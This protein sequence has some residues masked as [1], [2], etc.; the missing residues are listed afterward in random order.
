MK[1]HFSGI[2]GVYYHQDSCDLNREIYTELKAGYAIEIFAQ[3][4]F[5][6]RWGKSRI[7]QNENIDTL[8]GVCRQ[9]YILRQKGC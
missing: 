6:G 3:Y 8:L 1:G 4:F 2:C 9:L 7:Y 5:Q